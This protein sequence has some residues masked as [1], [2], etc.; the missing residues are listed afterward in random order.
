MTVDGG[1]AAF[2]RVDQHELRITP[3][4][5]VPAG[6]R[7]EV[8]VRYAG[9][10]GRLSYA[11]ERNW[12]ADADEVVTMNEPHM[13]P[14]WFPANDH[15]LD[16]ARFDIHVTVP[17]GTDVVAN[18]LPRGSEARA[19]GPPTT[20]ARPT[21]WRPTSRSSPPVILHRERGTAA[22][23]AVAHRGRASDAR[24]RGQVR[25][26]RLARTP[27]VTSGCEAAARGLPVRRDGRPGHRPPTSGFALENQTRPTY[28]RSVG[29]S[30]I[31]LLVHELAHQWFG[32]SVS[33]RGW[34]DIWL[35]EGFASY[36]EA[37]WEET[38]GGPSAEAWLR[39]AHDQYGADEEFWKLA[40][41]DPGAAADLR[42][43]RLRPRRDDA[44]AL[45]NSSA[46]GRSR[47]CCRTWVEQP[48]AATPP[49]RTSWAL[50]EQVSGRTS[51]PSS[52]PGSSRPRSRPTPPPT[53]SADDRP[54]GWRQT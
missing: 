45:R 44:G 29:G 34:R 6:E 24:Q 12:L 41:A 50:A 19:G 4:K 18:G 13:A 49:P 46:T 54:A 11:G 17:R 2:R 26:R 36:I 51:T 43:G 23:T 21:R 8:V 5:P 14:W 15:P 42:R 39:R 7:F 53:G 32:D 9:K 22:G 31:Y 38:H 16:K 47:R 28:P 30:T 35:N 10:P 20:G 27:E 48:G 33:V 40:I 25:R 1:R 37:R 52:T 3:D